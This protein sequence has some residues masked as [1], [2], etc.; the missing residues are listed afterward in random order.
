MCKTVQL[1]GI[2]MFIIMIIVIII[3]II[4]IS[5]IVKSRD[6]PFKSRGHGVPVGLLG[7]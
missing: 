4:A 5:M 1:T 2:S 6:L 3:A 7:V